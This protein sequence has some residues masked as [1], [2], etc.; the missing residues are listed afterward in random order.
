LRIP[1]ERRD[2]P[3]GVELI[4]KYVIFQFLPLV[5]DPQSYFSGFPQS[6]RRKVSE[7]ARRELVAGLTKKVG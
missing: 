6:W 4:E 1:R 3:E 5:Q 7:Q 2:S